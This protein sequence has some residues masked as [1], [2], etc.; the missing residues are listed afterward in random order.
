MVTR[1]RKLEYLAYQTLGYNGK[2]LIELGLISFLLGGCVALFVVA[3]DLLPALLGSGVAQVF[4]ATDVNGLNS[5]WK[6]IFM[7]ALS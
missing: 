4:T 2:L 7:V 5:Y 1:R 3:G 6:T